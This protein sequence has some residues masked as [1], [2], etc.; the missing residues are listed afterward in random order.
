[1]LGGITFGYSIMSARQAAEEARRVIE[2]EGQA[3]RFGFTTMPDSVPSKIEGVPSVAQNEQFEDD[4][5]YAW[6]NWRARETI[7]LPFW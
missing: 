5:Y 2:T 4:I 7:I 1:V 3:Q 6:K